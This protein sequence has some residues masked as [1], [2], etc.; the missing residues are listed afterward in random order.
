LQV[1][2]DVFQST[3]STSTSYNVF[4]GL[5]LG[6]AISPTLVAGIG[7][8]SSCSTSPT[9]AVTMGIGYNIFGGKSERGIFHALKLR[10]DYIVPKL[11]KFAEG[12]I[13]ITLGA[14][15]GA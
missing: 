8:G 4:S 11:D 12:I 9:A 10:A 2:I 15:F 6:Y 1:G 13:G 5:H 3:N 14:S 7:I